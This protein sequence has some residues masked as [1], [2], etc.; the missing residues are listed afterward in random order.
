MTSAGIPSKSHDRQSMR[1][2]GT[3]GARP[4]QGRF[5][6]PLRW[7]LQS[8]GRNEGSKTLDRFMAD[9]LAW[10]SQQLT[11]VGLARVG[12]TNH[13]CRVGDSLLQL[14]RWTASEVWML[15][16]LRIVRRL[17]DRGVCLFERPAGSRTKK[18]RGFAAEKRGRGHGG[19][20]I[21]APL[22]LCL[23]RWSLFRIDLLPPMPSEESI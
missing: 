5:G 4:G 2:G 23:R 13:G 19:E 14:V 6:E 18:K 22:S 3:A 7:D 17:V 1:P 12:A 8:N 11:A 9:W 21:G 20:F 15:Q 16:Q 10:N